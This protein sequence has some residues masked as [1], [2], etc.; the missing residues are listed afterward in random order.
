MIQNETI[1]IKQ[2]D[3][4]LHNNGISNDEKYSTMMDVLMGKKLDKEPHTSIYSLLS[5]SNIPHYDLFQIFFM[6]FGNKFFKKD[7]N[8]FYTPR[9]ISN[10]ICSLLKP[11]LKAID[12]ACGTGDLINLYKGYITLCDTSSEVLE[13]TKTICSLLGIESQIYHMDSLKELVNY[14][15]QYDYCIMNPPF[16]TSTLITDKSILENY[17]MGRHLKKQE[18]GILFLELGLRLLKPNGVLFIIVPNGYL[19]NQT[20][21]C[22]RLRQ[23]ILDSY[24][25]LGIIQLPE[26]S[27]SRSG[28]GVSTSILIIQN[29]KDTSNYNV[30]ISCIKHIGYHL[31]KKNTPIKYKMNE[32][33]SY[34]YNELKQ[35]I[36]DNDFEYLSKSFIQFIFDNNI[37]NL[38]SE[39]TQHPYT[40]CL[41]NELY[42]FDVKRFL[43]SYLNVRK[44]AI[45]NNYLPL[46]AYCKQ[47]TFDFT[48]N[49]SDV[50]Y[51]IDI[52]SVHTPMYSFRKCFYNNLPT[53]GK[54][55]V[56]KND[57]I[58]SRLK[59]TI[60]FTIIVHDIDNLI[61]SNGF[62]VFR[63]NGKTE[64][65][66]LFGN[67]FSE[68]FRIQ[69]QSLVTGSIMETINN[70]DISQILLNPSIN[71][72]KFEKVLI[73]LPIM[74]NI[75]AV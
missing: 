25:L 34:M 8:Q 7:L 43:P 63:P 33:G 32:D 74:C 17:Y 55:K 52:G 14:Y 54:Y 45:L 56:Q 16:G 27:F 38:V 26:N 41:K 40:T 30:F 37:S 75:V 22:I 70:D 19:G 64:L 29:N 65:L 13:I 9:T 68:S 20:N 67:L 46:S 72:D 21:S 5:T 31:N 6:N 44:K 60:S 28:T 18:I 10:F 23:F 61:V 50:Y 53:R 48:K 69:H 3:Q 57:I 58:I 1:F 35:P 73:A 36:I 39:N 2:I 15:N 24:K 47:T 62:S 42:I 66:I 49:K 12:P 11:N 71:T 51:Y 59:G 4:L